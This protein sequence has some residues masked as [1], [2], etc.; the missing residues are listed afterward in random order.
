MF[1]LFGVSP[2]RLLC[3]CSSCW[4]QKK[5]PLGFEQCR[6]VN[7]R[8]VSWVFEEPGKTCFFGYKRDF[9]VRISKI[10]LIQSTL[11]AASKIIVFERKVRS[12][13]QQLQQRERERWLIY[14][15]SLHHQRNGF[16]ILQFPFNKGG[17]LS[18]QTHKFL[19]LLGRAGK[20]AGI[21]LRRRPHLS[22]EPDRTFLTL[23]NDSVGST[24]GRTGQICWINL[25]ARE[26]TLPCFEIRRYC[27]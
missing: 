24:S 18:G 15:L 8:M 10:P 6:E 13:R 26:L 23:A 21:A 14:K 25:L 12:S 3:Q 20:R 1:N 27:S 22:D 9:F 19:F 7:V 5:R 4:D 11:Q 16:G 17:I 2:E